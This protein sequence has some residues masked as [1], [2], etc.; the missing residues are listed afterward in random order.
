M[1]VD[2]AF[3]W[4][5]R[6]APALGPVRRF[7]PTGECAAAGEPA[8]RAQ[9]A[10]AAHAAV[11]PENKSAAVAQALADRRPVTGA[12]RAQGSLER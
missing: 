12:E 3:E 7:D 11:P 10:L 2:D 5:A 9:G 6:L 1:A 8:G 4:G